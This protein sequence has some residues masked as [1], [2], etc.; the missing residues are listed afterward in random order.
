MRKISPQERELLS[1]CRE[2]GPTAYPIEKLMTEWIWGNDEIKGPLTT[3]ATKKA[4]IESFEAYLDLLEMY[5]SAPAPY[6]GR[7]E[8]PSRYY[9]QEL[10]M[11]GSTK[12]GLVN[13]TQMIINHLEDKNYREALLTAVD[14]LDR[15]QSKQLAIRK[16][17]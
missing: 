4:A 12:Q 16:A 3:F 9:S 5:E 17:L 15:L 6:W 11:P 14:L 8:P 2:H 7:G 10:R 13:H 1:R